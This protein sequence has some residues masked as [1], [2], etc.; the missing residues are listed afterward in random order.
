[1]QVLFEKTF[2]KDI[3]KYSNDFYNNQLLK[4]IELLKVQE[5]FS[6]IKSVKK[7]KGGG[8]Y[9]RIRIGEFRVGL[10]YNDN[11]ITFIRFMHRK[12]IYKYF[13]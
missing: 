8:N 5:K 1:M 4:L 11:K 2:L 7:M 6:D 10:K 12:D 3:Q 13:Q 9:Y